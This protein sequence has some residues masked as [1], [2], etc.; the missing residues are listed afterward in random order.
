MISRV[1]LIVRVPRVFAEYATV[2]YM[3]KRIQMRKNRFQKIAESMKTARENPGPPGV[4][5]DHGD[6]APKQTVSVKSANL[7]YPIRL[8][9][10]LEFTFLFDRRCE[11]TCTR[12]IREKEKSL[13]SICS[14]IVI[15]S[16]DL[17]SA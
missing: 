17:V 15:I 12:L 4:P 9:F 16:V 5:G 7:S 1:C 11:K 3:A 2:G 8:S 14:R 10:R 6:H 13:F